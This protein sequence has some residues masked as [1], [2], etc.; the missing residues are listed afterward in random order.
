[1]VHREVMNQFD[2]VEAFK[3]E[4]WDLENHWYLFLDLV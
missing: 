2:I 3:K 4:L 1:M